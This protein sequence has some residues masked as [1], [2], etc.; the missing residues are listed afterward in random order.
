MTRSTAPSLLDAGPRLVGA[1]ILIGCDLPEAEDLVQAAMLKCY[2]SWLKMSKADR[3]EYDMTTE[4]TMRR[5]YR[6][7]SS[8]GSFIPRPSTS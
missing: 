3:L 8:S 4:D 1:A 2:V 6:L 5:C 7:P